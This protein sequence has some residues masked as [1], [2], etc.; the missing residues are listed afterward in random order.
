VYNDS[1]V[2]HWNDELYLPLFILPQLRFVQFNQH[3]FKQSLLRA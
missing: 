1:W 2:R 3:L